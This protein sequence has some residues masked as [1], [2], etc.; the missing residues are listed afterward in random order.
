MNP[1]KYIELII[2][3]YAS[4]N[5]HFDKYISNKKPSIRYNI[6]FIKHIFVTKIT[7]PSNYKI[8]ISLMY[9]Q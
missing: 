1:P 6:Y 9:V 7:I 2:L 4:P 8:L 5:K 3:M